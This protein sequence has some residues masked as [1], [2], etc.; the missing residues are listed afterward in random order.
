MN[1][2]VLARCVG[3]KAERWIGPGEVPEG[4]MPICS[5]CFMP[6]TAV[7]AEALMSDGQRED[8]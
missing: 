2:R 4:D 3:C 7:R 5:E 8:Q 1:A 6:M